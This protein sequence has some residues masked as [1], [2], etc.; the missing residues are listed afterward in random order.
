[1]SGVM[2]NIAGLH[3]GDTY[4]NVVVLLIQREEEKQRQLKRQQE[5]LMLARQHY[6][7]NVLL[8]RGLAPWKRL[9]QLRQANIRVNHL[10]PEFP[11][12][13]NS[14][15]SPPCVSNQHFDDAGGLLRRSTIYLP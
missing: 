8:R 6:H 2:R 14:V 13:R 3:P 1:M 7:R 10:S 4:S 9:V 5:L 12:V 11:V 15:S